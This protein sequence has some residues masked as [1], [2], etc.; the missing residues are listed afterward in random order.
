[1]K[2]ITLLLLSALVL[3]GCTH[4]A[5]YSTPPP[6]PPPAYSEVAREGFHDGV[7]AADRDVRDGRRPDVARHPKFR[8]PPVGP[9]LIEDYR[10]GFRSGYD[11]VFRHE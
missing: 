3:T 5:Y 1:M 2:R 9:P 7:L 8:N 6:A 10:Q 11:R 4:R